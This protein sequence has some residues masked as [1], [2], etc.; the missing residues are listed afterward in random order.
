MAR[1]IGMCGRSGSGK[2][3]ICRLFLQ[4]GIPSIDTDAVYRKLTAASPIVSPCVL[5][6][7]EAFGSSVMAEDGSLDRKQLAKIVFAPDGA[8]ALRRL[9]EITH[10][11]ILNETVVLLGRMLSMGAPAVILDAPV[12]FESHLDQLCDTVV[13]VAADDA[14]SI[15]RIMERDGVTEEEAKARLAAQIP[16]AELA[17]RCDYV[18]DNSDGSLPEG[19]VKALAASFI[20]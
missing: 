14:S 17:A 9:N 19:Q 13:C 7:A 1:I 8:D 6:L 12:L 2:S 18:V 15:R 10:K 4:Y 11:Y 20:R 5:E 3:T 16:L